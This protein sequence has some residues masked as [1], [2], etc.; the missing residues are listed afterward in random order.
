MPHGNVA[1]NRPGS[2]V[3]VRRCREC[4]VTETSNHGNCILPS[5]PSSLGRRVVVGTWLVGYQTLKCPSFSVRLSLSSTLIVL[6]AFCLC[7]QSQFSKFRVAKF[8]LKSPSHSTFFVT[9]NEWTYL[10]PSVHV[11]PAILGFEPLTLPFL[12]SARSHLRRHDRR[13]VRLLQVF[14]GPAGHHAAAQ[15]QVHLNVQLHQRGDREHQD[16]RSP[17]SWHNLKPFGPFKLEKKLRRPN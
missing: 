8:M 3:S 5:L 6:C 12:F 4:L 11:N 2:S 16:E 13:V 10:K 1:R 17:F 14:R 7:N 15:D 9:R